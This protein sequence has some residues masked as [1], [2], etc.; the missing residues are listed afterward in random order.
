MTPA[1]DQKTQHEARFSPKAVENNGANQRSIRPS[2]LFLAV[3][4]V[5]TLSIV[6][7]LGL[8]GDADDIR[9]DISEVTVRN[10]G[11]VELT[12]ASYHGRLD[13]GEAYEINAKVASEDKNG[14]GHINLTAPVALLHNEGG[15][16]VN[17]AS[18]TGTFYQQSNSIDLSGNVIVTDTQRQMTM[19]T[20]AMTA[21]F[22]AGELL[23]QSA[24]VVDNPSTHITANGMR[25][26]NNGDR[27]IFLGN[28]KMTLHTTQVLQ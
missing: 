8:F 25:V 5:I 27:V 2:L 24:V 23:A 16:T 22:S 4:M 14:S 20:E 28:A 15:G 17:V 26:E 19:R 12:G 1:P 18:N 13:S 3:G 21:D 11:N 7:W 10:D 6:S 9:L